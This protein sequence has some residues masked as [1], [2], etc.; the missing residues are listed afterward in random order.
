MSK[1]GKKPIQ[2]PTGVDIK[3]DGGAI[4][5]KGP[6]GTLTCEVPAALSVSVADGTVLVVPAE[7]RSG[8]E[9]KHHIALWG[10][11]RALIQNMVVG[12]TEGYTKSLELNGIGYK[13]ILKGKDLEISLGFSHPINYQA[14]EGIT[15]TVEKNVVTVS[16]ID[17]ELVGFVAAQIRALKVPDPYKAHGVKYAG[18]FIKTKTGKKAATATA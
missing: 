2:I 17:R 8:R 5:V 7:K 13:A 16:G 11:Y 6:K 1:I 9:G 14:P 10:L 3:I 18:E 12:V 4:S 15:F